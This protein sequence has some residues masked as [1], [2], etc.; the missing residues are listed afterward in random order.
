[1]SSHKELKNIIDKF[2]KNEVNLASHK[3]ELAARKIDSILSDAN[4]LD[5]KLKSMEDKFDK[6]Y[7]QYKNNYKEWIGW[8]NDVESSANKLE[9][10]LVKIMDV[11]QEIGVDGRSIDGFAKTSDLVTRLKEISKNSKQLY[12]KVD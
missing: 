3:V 2:P 11:A 4:K 1:M 7:V 12:P 8:L 10:D 9:D 6:F 5:N